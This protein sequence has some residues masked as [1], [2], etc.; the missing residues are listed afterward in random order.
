MG[1]RALEGIRVLDLTQTLSGPYGTM[2]LADLGAEVVKIES[3]DRP[4]RARSVPPYFRGPDSLYYLSLNRNKKSLTLNLKHPTGLQI[5]YNLV[6]RADVVVDNFRPGVLARLGV[7]Y[8]HLRA[9]NPRIICCSL[10][11]FGRTGPYQHRPG[12]DYLIQALAGTMSLT[13]EPGGP[14]TKYG[15]SIVDHVGGVFLALAVV[16]ALFWRAQTGVGA[17]LDLAL[18]DTHLSLLTYVAANFLNAGAVPQRTARSAHPTIVPAQLFETQDG[19]VVIMPLEE[20]FWPALCRAVDH[21]EWADDARYASASAR[22]QHRDELVPKL[23]DLFRRETTAYWLER[24]E[25]YDVPCAP[26]LTVPEALSDPQVRARG[27][28]RTFSHPVYGTFDLID[29]PLRWPEAEP[30]TDPPP[31][32]GEQTVCVLR[33]WLGMDPATINQLRDQGVC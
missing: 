16:A 12:Y 3:P 28:V 17:D 25:R 20:H 9:Y 8:A 26:V 21:P 22:L 5:F 30:R 27:L 15:I 18:L 2:L 29:T 14:P 32:L 31:V 24:L 4:D 1:T 6:R 7:D 23:E 10:S 19:Y 13:G 11:A 33:E